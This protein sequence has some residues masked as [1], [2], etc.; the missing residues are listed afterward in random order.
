MLASMRF[1]LLIILFFVP[2]LIGCP[3]QATQR[4][5]VTGLV[6]VDVSQMPEG[7]VQME[8]EDKEQWMNEITYIQEWLVTQPAKIIIVPDDRTDLLPAANA[9]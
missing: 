3:Y 4:V 1:L 2:V 9:R 7:A 6:V 8:R 5:V